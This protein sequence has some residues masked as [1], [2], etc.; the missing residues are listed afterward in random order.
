MLSRS[1]VFGSVLLSFLFL[2]TA[3]P[4]AFAT[5]QEQEQEQTQEQ[6]Q[7]T[8]TT[9]Q[10]AQSPAEIE[11]DTT[12][13]DLTADE[14]PPELDD[15]W[16]TTDHFKSGV[17]PDVDTTWFDLD[18]EGRP[19]EATA[20]D[21]TTTDLPPTIDPV[22]IAHRGAPAYV[23][24]HTA[25]GVAMAHAFGVDFIEQDVVLSRDGVPV[26]LHD[27]RLDNVSNVAEVFPDRTRPDGHYYAMDF[28]VAELKQLTL[29]ERI[30]YKDKPKSATDEADQESSEPESGSE[31]AQENTDSGAETA[32]EATTQT[33][34]QL[35]ADTEAGEIDPTP[36]TQANKEKGPERYRANKGKLKQPVYPERFPI[37]TGNFRITTLAEQLTLIQG[38]NKSRGKN[39]GVYIELKSSRWHSQQGY[40]LMAAVMAELSRHGY[41]DPKEPLPTPIYLQSFD[42][43]DLRRWSREFHTQ[44]SLVQ[45]IAENSWNEASVDY[46][47]MR[48]SAG[49]E[50]I[51]N[52]AHAIGVWVPHVLKGVTEDGRP[53]FTDIV[54]NARKA[55]LQVHV[56]TLRADALPDGVPD[57]ET[58]VE[59]LKQAGVDGYFTDFPDR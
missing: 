33:A 38:L 43:E 56:Y 45:L 23:P 55:G 36:V 59:W 15:T 42:P 16:L 11:I 9:E 32:D 29:T 52:Q 49:L 53:E 50:G 10:T 30:V 17:A 41:G 26:V 37:S 27:L 1:A 44:A 7:S 12:W 6:E 5:P 20:P 46:S 19:A 25:E 40:D 39:V 18:P 48:T 58:L 28:S 54:K 31:T 47:S 3:A 51:S 34:T 13:I 2:S 4:V 24:E 35:P 57:Y 22:K 8:E 14:V 21:T